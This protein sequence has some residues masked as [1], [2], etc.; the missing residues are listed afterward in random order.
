MIAFEPAY[1][2]TLCLIGFGGTTWSSPNA[3]N[4][5][6]ARS[7]F[8]KFTVAGDL[9]LIVASATS[10]RTPDAAG[11]AYRSQRR[12]DSSRSSVLAIA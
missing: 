5:I 1:F 8:L 6:G 9:R 12:S 7:S 3:M 11:T 4:S 10:K 2:S